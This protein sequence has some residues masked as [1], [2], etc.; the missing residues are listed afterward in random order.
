MR[1][2]RT[3]SSN[4]FTYISQLS[5]T[6]SYQ[7]SVFLCSYCIWNVQPVE[8]RKCDISLASLTHSLLQ[9]YNKALD[10]YNIDNIRTWRIIFP[11]CNI[12][13]RSNVSYQ[14]HYVSGATRSAQRVARYM[15][16]VARYAIRVA[17]DSPKRKCLA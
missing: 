10:L 17:Q 2:T 6:V 3:L 13:Y 16:R 12:Q 15:I 8:L 4:T 1:S 5:R 7:R 9:Y 14:S 11:R